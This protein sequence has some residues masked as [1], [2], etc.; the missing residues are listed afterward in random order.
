MV[1]LVLM[2]AVLF[3]TGPI[4]KCNRGLHYDMKRRLGIIN[5]RPI[6]GKIISLAISTM[7]LYLVFPV[8]LWIVWGIKSHS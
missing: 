2:G 4:M 7:P 5:N 1:N 8:Y 6:R 3:K